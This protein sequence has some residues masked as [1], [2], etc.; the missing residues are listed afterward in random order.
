MPNHKQGTISAVQSSRGSGQADSVTLQAIFP[1][2]PLYEGADQFASPEALREE[3]QKLV[4]DGV[5]NDG[6]HTFGTFNMDFS[7]SP[8]L[9]SV[10]TGGGGL[11]ASPYTPN[12]A[13][14]G[15]GSMNPTDQPAPPAGFGEKPNSQ[16]GTGVGSQLNP[17]NSSE[18]IAAQKIGEL[19]PNRSST[20]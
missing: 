10:K 18:A 9:E 6:G 15:P 12:P 3:Y 17:K 1:T 5:I 16:W 13:S 8:N 2:S 19:A 20:E 7:D 14:P 11:P 4:M